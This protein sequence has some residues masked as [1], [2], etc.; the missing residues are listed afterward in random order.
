MCKVRCWPGK[1]DS[2]QSRGCF[3]HSRPVI[4]VELRLA[5][6]LPLHKG[7]NAPCCRYV[8]TQCG[9]RPRATAV[10]IHHERE[11]MQL[12]RLNDE[13]S[14]VRKY[15]KGERAYFPAVEILNLSISASTR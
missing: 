3:S 11:L 6:K 15:D 8:C 4:V 10:S 5:A 7:H 13:V 9:V 2:L 1:L 14:M 12:I